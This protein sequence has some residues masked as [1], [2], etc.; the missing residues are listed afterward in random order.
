MAVAGIAIDAPVLAG[1]VVAGTVGAW[2]IGV[3]TQVTL[4]S[5]RGAPSAGASCAARALS[6]VWSAE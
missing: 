2:L 6:A 4:A 1:A 3:F 5:R